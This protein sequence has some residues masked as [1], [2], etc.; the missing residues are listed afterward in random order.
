M[1]EIKDTKE[2][3]LTINKNGLSDKYKGLDIK[4][5]V[6]DV[7]TNF[8][9]KDIY[10]DFINRKLE[11]IYSKENVI[12]EILISD[13]TIKFIDI[14]DESFIMDINT[15]KIIIYLSYDKYYNKKNVP[16]KTTIS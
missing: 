1:D 9:I 7:L 4:E 10:I 3:A 13:I 8:K 2:L 11:I 12:N 5:N 16:Y 15:D 6:Y 14:I